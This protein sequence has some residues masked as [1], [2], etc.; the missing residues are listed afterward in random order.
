ME[1]CTFKALS[2]VFTGRLFTGGDTTWRKWELGT[3]LNLTNGDL[4][5]SQKD[6]KLILEV[7]GDEVRPAN[8]V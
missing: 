3:S 7:L 1:K 2:F 4:S 8:H 6:I 5:M